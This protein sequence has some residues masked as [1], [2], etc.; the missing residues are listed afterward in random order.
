MMMNIQYLSAPQ[1]LS[2][3]GVLAN[4]MRNT[5]QPHSQAHYWP[6]HK[7]WCCCWTQERFHPQMN[8]G[9]SLLSPAQQGKTWKVKVFVTCWRPKKGPAWKKRAKGNTF[10]PAQQG[11]HEK[12]KFML[13][14]AGWKRDQHEK[15]ERKDILFSLKYFLIPPLVQHHCHCTQ[16]S[17]RNPRD[18]RKLPENRWQ[19]FPT[20]WF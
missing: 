1:P 3:S 4:M 15:R 19:C 2:L 12:W 6:S 14:A 20:L 17:C 11:G 16:S 8:R 13:L 7:S 5:S 10:Q 18:S 9:S